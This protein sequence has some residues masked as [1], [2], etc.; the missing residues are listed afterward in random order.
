MYADS[1]AAAGL[2]LQKASWWVDV[3][4]K[5]TSCLESTFRWVAVAWVSLVYCEILWRSPTVQIFKWVTTSVPR[6]HWML[7]NHMIR[8]HKVVMGGPVQALR[9]LWTSSKLEWRGSRCAVFE[10]VIAAVDVVAVCCW[11]LAEAWLSLQIKHPVP[12]P[13]GLWWTEYRHI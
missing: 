7:G 10:A 4:A 6:L 11:L 2:Q 1:D 9:C 3:K 13:D 8:Y 12:V 5:K